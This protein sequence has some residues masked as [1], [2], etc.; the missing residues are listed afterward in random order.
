MLKGSLRS[1][2][3]RGAKS[4]ERGFRRFARAKNG[5]ALYSTETLATQASLKASAEITLSF[6]RNREFVR[7]RIDTKCLFQ[8]LSE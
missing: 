6:L 2:R 1:K 4:E 3:F 5:F 7:S 8:H